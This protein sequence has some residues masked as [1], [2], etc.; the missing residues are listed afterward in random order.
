MASLLIV[1]S[2]VLVTSALCS[3]FE[4]VLYSVPLSHVE[5]LVADGRRSGRVLKKL[6]DKVEAPITAILSLNTISNTAGAAVAGA[7]ASRVLGPERLVFFSVAFTVAILLLSEVVPKTAGVIYARPFARFVARPLQILTWLFSPVVW[8]IGFVTRV[9]A[10]AGSSEEISAEEIVT[11]ARLGL[12]SGVIDE[13]ESKVIENALTLRTKTVREVLTPRS[14]TFSLDQDLTVGQ[15]HGKRRIAVHS[16]F[17]VFDEDPNDICGLVESQDVLAAAARDEMETTL[18]ELSRPIHLVPETLTLDRALG[19]FL[20]TH[21]HL[22]G[23]IDEFGG[24]AGVVTLEDVVEELLGREIV[25]A[26]DLVPDMRELARVKRDALMVGRSVFDP[27]AQPPGEGD[28]NPSEG[29]D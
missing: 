19:S 7:L 1:V 9:V 6:R 13:G 16:R 25:D 20:K 21:D 17:P 8:I 28:E 2:I 4:A 23:V 18:K 14:V 10:S 15:A 29:T 3:L 5:A 22:F 11:L 26:S 12:R 27:D 24:F